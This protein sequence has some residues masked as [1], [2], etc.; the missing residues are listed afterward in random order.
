MDGECER[1]EGSEKER[2]REGEGGGERERERLRPLSSF[3][4]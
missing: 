2:K 1:L 4:A 3:L